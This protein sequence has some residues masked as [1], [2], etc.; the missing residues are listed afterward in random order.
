MKKF[1]TSGYRS[2]IY[3]LRQ[4]ANDVLL[5]YDL[6]VEQ[7][8][9][10]HH[11]E[12]T[13]FEIVT[14]KGSYLLRIH[15]DSYHTEE[16]IREEL[17]WLNKL[18]ESGFTAQKPIPSKENKLITY[19]EYKGEY[20]KRRC[21]VL[22]W[23][24]G[25]FRG[26]SLTVNHS[27]NYGR[28]FARL[29]NPACQIPIK[30]RKYWHADGLLGKDDRFTGLFAIEEGL[31]KKQYTVF[32]ECRETLLKKIK[33]YEK[34]FPEKF[35]LIHADMHFENLVWQGYN[36]V[37]I[38]FDDC[39]SG[40]H[41][42]DICIYLRSLE[43]TLKRKKST[44]TAAYF[45]AFMEGYSEFGSITKADLE[46]LPYMRLAR[47]VTMFAW[48]YSRRDN[49]SIF[50]FFKKSRKPRIEKYKQFLK[51]GPERFFT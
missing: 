42:Y 20:L 15:R 28:L 49:P 10:I 37:P 18:N 11:G 7:L 2:Q 3:Q 25:I 32:N 33:Q 48:G 5:Q 8:K 31:T 44:K 26:D 16:G 45:D 40:L 12:N 39:G 17:A 36:P 23:Q 19:G 30:H 14:R 4:L 21:T 24:D 41:L 13:T 34:K 51:E 47:D 43:N 22:T 38:D 29:H 50:E 35:G 1:E 6:K 46:V 9:Y 27:R